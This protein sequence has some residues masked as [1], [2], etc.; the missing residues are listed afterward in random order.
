MLETLVAFSIVIALCLMG[1]P[2]AFVTLLVGTVGVAMMRGLDASIIM[3]SQQVM[4]MFMKESLAVIPIFILMGNLIFRAGIAKELYDAGYATLGRYRGGLAMSTILSCAGFSAVC[5]SSLATSAT[6]SKVAMPSMRQYRYSDSLSTGAIAAGGTLGI[7]IP[8]SVPLI[9]YGVIAEQDIGLLFM[10]GILPGALLVLLY[11]IVAAGWTRLSPSSGPAAA[12]SSIME[13]L[14]ATMLVWPVVVLFLVILGGIY[15]G[16]FTPTEAASVGAGGALLFALLRG[17]IR[18]LR[19]MLECLIDS[20][21][22]TAMILAVAAG[23]MVFANYLNMLGSPY[24]LV[25]AVNSLNLGPME[26]VMLIAAICIVLGMVFESIGILFLVIPV[27]LPTLLAS[28]I[29][30]IW[31]GIVVI[32]VIELGLITPPIGMNVFT[33][34]ATLPDVPLGTIFKGVTPFIFANLV[35][36]ILVFMVPEIA[37]FIPSLR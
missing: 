11:I 21:I 35:A 15:G 2:L 3:A 20:V 7:M 8:P 16:I 23:A 1:L 33:V 24:E 6:M 25:A 27:F 22:T 4:D 13:A 37:T 17:R 30:M 31:F 26:I 29:D 12:P 28:N 10:A 32:I 34:K 5:G 18:S 14:R 36:L 19:D 9:I